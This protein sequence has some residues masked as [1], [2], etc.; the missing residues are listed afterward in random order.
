MATTKAVNSP[1][2]KSRPD[3]PHEFVER[4]AVALET[5]GFPRIAGRIFGLLIMSDVE[6]SLDEITSAVDASKASASVNTRMLEDKGLIER[7]SRPG[8]RRDYYRI[9]GDPFLR[10]MEQRLARWNRVRG[11]VSDAMND[12]SLATSVRA[13]LREFDAMSAE[14]GSLVEAT[15][16]RL[17]N[18]KRK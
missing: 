3:V 10:T 12:A 16:A 17:R 11:V 9:A 1:K 13:R 5:D 8:D 4:L 15:L 14:C 7:V 2:R 6:L 18:R